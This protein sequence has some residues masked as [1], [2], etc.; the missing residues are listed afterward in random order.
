MENKK[1][2]ITDNLM[3]NAV[4]YL[5]ILAVTFLGI[6]L[7]DAGLTR[8]IGITLLVLFTILFALI[9]KSQ[10]VPWKLHIHLGLMTLIV[11]VL[12]TLEPAWSVFPMLFFVLSPTAMMAFS[13]KTGML[14]ILGFTLVTAIVFFIYAPPLQAL[15]GLL[16]FSAGFWFFGTFGRA[17]VSAEE[18]RIESQRLLKEVQEAHLQLQEYAARI[19]ELAISEERNRLSREMHDTLGHRLTVSAV[20]LE[21]AQRLI[22]RDPDRAEQMIETVRE[23]VRDALTELRRTVATLREPLEADLAL[24]SAINRLSKYFQEAT[25]LKIHLQ[26]PDEVPPLPHAHRLAIYRAAQ[27]ALTNIQKHANASQC[28]LRLQVE[29]GQVSLVVSDDGQGYPKE[30][31]EAAFGLMGMRERSA[32]LGGDLQ[33]DKRE[34]GGAELRL[35]LPLPKENHRD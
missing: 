24:S 2:G 21:G 19:E 35:T 32:H 31:R 22:H 25:D 27:E 34:N 4:G 12:M 18:A 29:P 11:A 15:A 20:Q 6:Q 7:F 13:L 28:W 1:K 5:A 8:I 26:I 3:M 33:L 30:I 16:P 9:P 23:Q 14:W 10:P 17:L